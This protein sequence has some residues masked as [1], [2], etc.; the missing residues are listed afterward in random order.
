MDY[1]FPHRR[2]F[3][4]AAKRFMRYRICLNASLLVVFAAVAAIGVK[5]MLNANLTFALADLSK[6]QDTASGIYFND[7]GFSILFRMDLTQMVLAIPLTYTQILFFLSVSALCFLIVAPLRMGAMDIFWQVL[8]GKQPTLRSALAWLSQAGRMGK[9][10]VVEFILQVGVRL[11]GILATVPSFYLYYLFYTNVTSI[12]QMTTQAALLQYLA[13]FLAAAAGGLSF[14]LHTLFL[15]VRY[16]LAAHPEYSLGETFRRG[17]KSMYGSR[18]R[19]FWFRLTFAP[20]FFLSQLTYNA[21][22]IF[23]LP[24]S[25]LAS[26]LY[27]QEVAREQHAHAQQEPEQNLAPQ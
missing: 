23:V 14:W 26:M 12:D 20:W 25:S 21:I 22:D 11:V 8:Q 27:I 2:E 6:Y 13:F 18:G 24:Y 9:A 16:C 4:I 5:N 19:F 1:H 3:K 17:L 7:N 15:P 10:V